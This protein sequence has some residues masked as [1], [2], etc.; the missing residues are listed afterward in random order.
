MYSIHYVHHAGDMCA[1]FACNCAMHIDQ[2]QKKDGNKDKNFLKKKVMYST[3]HRQRQNE[4]RLLPH[5]T[6]LLL[7]CKRGRGL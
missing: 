3:G 5:Q 2:L 6:R 4:T 1:E 7:K